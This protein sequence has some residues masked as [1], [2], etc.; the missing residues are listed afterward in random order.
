MALAD[1]TLI[2]PDKGT[3]IDQ[4]LWRVFVNLI[5][6]L[7]QL[8]IVVNTKGGHYETM[9]DEQRCE[10]D[11]ILTKAGHPRPRFF[12]CILPDC[13]ECSQPEASVVRPSGRWN[14]ACCLRGYYVKQNHSNA[15][16]HACARRGLN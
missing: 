11:L 16:E 1:C 12:F 2:N 3:H 13:R 5:W 4:A 7:K 15:F 10:M 6:R 9:L 8:D 14:F